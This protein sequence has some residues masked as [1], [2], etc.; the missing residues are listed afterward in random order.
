MKTYSSCEIEYF[1]ETHLC[2]LYLVSVLGFLSLLVSK[3]RNS[4]SEQVWHWWRI[5]TYDSKVKVTEWSYKY[6]LLRV[7]YYTR[8]TNDRYGRWYCSVQ[9]TFLPSEQ[10][11]KDHDLRL[12][13]S[14]N[15]GLIENISSA[16]DK[17]IHHTQRPATAIVEGSRQQAHARLCMKFPCTVHLINV[18][19][20]TEEELRTSACQR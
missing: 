7:E 4:W 12:R 8:N 19:G 11:A 10:V 17:D 15:L 3:K 20:V 1:V 13:T 2:K 16:D 18:C 6:S 5:P 9:C 14:I